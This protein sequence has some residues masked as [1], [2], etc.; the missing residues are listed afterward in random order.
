MIND[1]VQINREQKAGRTKKSLIFDGV[2]LAVPNY[3]RT[4]TF[5]H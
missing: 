5:T 1:T 2:K 4:Q 3:T